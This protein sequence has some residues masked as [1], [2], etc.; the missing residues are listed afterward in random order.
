[1]R[2][3]LI[4]IICIVGLLGWGAPAFSSSL[5]PT[6]NGTSCS[7]GGPNG[8]NAPGAGGCPNGQCGYNGQNG[9]GRMG[10]IG[11]GGGGGPGAGGGGGGGCANGVCRLPAG[12]IGGGGGNAGGKSSQDMVDCLKKGIG[13]QVQ[14]AVIDGVCGLDPECEN[15]KKAYDIMTHS[16][17]CLDACPN[18]KDSWNMDKCTDVLCDAVGD[19]HPALKAVCKAKGWAE[20]ARDCVLIPVI[21]E[22]VTMACD[23]GHA[24]DTAGDP[25]P[26]TAC[27]GQANDANI[28]QQFKHSKCMKCC[29]RNSGAGADGARCEASCNAAFQ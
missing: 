5:L 29:M 26:P 28:G 3:L 12:G 10:P 25:T 9:N 8:P 15:L 24:I 23:I 7:I 17:E 1:M 20:V 22:T 18:I 11:G 2:N 13:E 21:V 6:C 4:N 19:L 27:V 14:G 16:K